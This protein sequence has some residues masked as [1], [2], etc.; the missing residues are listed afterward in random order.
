MRRRHPR[1]RADRADGQDLEADRRRQ[2]Q[3]QSRD[4]GRHRPG[5]L[6]RGRPLGYP[7]R[8]QGRLRGLCPA[9]APAPG[10]G[11]PATPGHARHRRDRRG[12]C[13]PCRADDPHR[14]RRFHPRQ[15]AQRDP[16]V[17]PDRLH[18]RQARIPGPYRLGLARRP[19]DLDGGFAALNQTTRR[20]GTKPGANTRPAKS[21]RAS[22]PDDES[23]HVP[24]HPS[25]TGHRPGPAPSPG[26][27]P[28]L[29]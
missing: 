10:R 8:R 14:P 18:L 27:G 15:Q 13:R 23:G 29:F 4:R 26:A 20:A 24:T 3:G 12:E 11:R 2:S 17:E 5:P 21:R 6:G 1:G 9:E 28:L 22:P 16:A 7:D 19:L 25:P